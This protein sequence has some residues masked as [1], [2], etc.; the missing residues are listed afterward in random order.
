MRPTKMAEH[1]PGL[2]HEILVLTHTYGPSTIEGSVLRVHDPSFNRH[3]IG[4]KKLIWLRDRLFCE[5]L[6]RC[7]RYHSIY[8]RWL[9]RASREF[10]AEIKAFAPDLVFSTYSPVESLEL[11]L[12]ISRDLN[13]PLIS[14][15]R[16]GLLFEPIEEKRL[17]MHD[18][19]RLHYLSIEKHAVQES[20]AITCAL[21]RLCR[22]FEDHYGI[23]TTVA[24]PNGFDPNDFRDLP[25]IEIEKDAF[26]I[27]HTGSFARSDITCDIAPWARA[28]EHLF[29]DHPEL[30]SRVRWHQ[31]GRLDKREQGLLSTLVSKGIVI[32]HGEVDRD[33]CLAFQKQADLLLL[34]TSLTRQSV[35]PGK[36]FEYLG[37]DR[38]IL[39]LTDTTFAAEILKI[40]RAGRIVH[41][42]REDQIQQALL[43]AITGNWRPEPDQAAI[44]G[45]SIDAQMKTLARVIRDLDR[46]QG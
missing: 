11:G 25:K 45:Y 1:L 34:I 29:I 20:H 8:S 15:F 32:D 36:I 33:H 13:I 44:E 5:I 46:A 7:G 12:R 14:D 3:R 37:A 42:A 27:V 19:V 26:N 40:T 43:D 16:D 4:A 41:P 17:A 23:D 10:K 31:L 35:T 38:P 2:G 18:C 24:L 28:L 9:N 6:N 39:G 22:Y 21:P 30:S